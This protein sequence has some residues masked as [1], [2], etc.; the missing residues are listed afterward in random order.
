[1]KTKILY[2]LVS[3]SNDIFWE[4]TF[5]SISSLRMTNQNVSVTILMDKVT[6]DSLIGVRSR[7]KNIVDEIIV[8]DLPKYSTNKEKSRIL[9]TNMRNYVNGD[10]LFIDSDTIILSDLSEIDNVTDDISAVYERNRIVS[11]DFGRASYEEALMRFDCKLYDS[12]E[13]FNSGVMLVKDKLETRQFFSEWHSQWMKGKKLGIMFDQPSLGVV[14]QKYNSFIKPLDGSWNCQGRFCLKYIYTAKIFHYLFDSS[15]SFPLMSKDLFL[16]LKKTGEL[17]TQLNDII[18][19]PFYYIS[20]NNEILT[21]SD[22]K[23]FHSRMYSF[24]RLL[25]E[26]LPFLYSSVEFLLNNIYGCILKFKKRN[27]APPR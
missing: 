8:I 24:I 21:G 15:F 16:E 2:V 23:R 3:N 22:V 10:F 4:Q 6:H 1:M 9:K 25:D 7:L 17:S 27:L 11:E 20:S 14:N 12:D 13:Y 26:K 19:N 5:V 18:N